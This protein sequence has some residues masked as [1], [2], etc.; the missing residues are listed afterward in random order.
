MAE[1][2][3]L[4]L[5]GILRAEFFAGGVNANPKRPDRGGAKNPTRPR[6]Q[7]KLWHRR[8]AARS[9]AMSHLLIGVVSRSLAAA[10]AASVRVGACG[11]KLHERAQLSTSGR[12]V[13]ASLP[14]RTQFTTT[15]GLGK[16]ASFFCE[17]VRQRRFVRSSS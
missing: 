1:L 14:V 17:R 2:E 5:L 12:P 7:I 8:R 6:Q 9:I 3:G 4:F 10:D 15:P 16:R 13:G 11:T